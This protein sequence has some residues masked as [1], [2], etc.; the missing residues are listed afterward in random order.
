MDRVGPKAVIDMCR[1]LGVKSDIPQSP[2]IALGAVEITVS[3]MVAAYSTF[4]N[5]GVYVKPRFISKI[6]DKSGVVLFESRRSEEHTSELQSR[7]HLVCRL[8][9]EK[10]KKNN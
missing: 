10:K 1:D 5:Q 3:D 6:T 9:L 4:A 2:A 7:P 8:L